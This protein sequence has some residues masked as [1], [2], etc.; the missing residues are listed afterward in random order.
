[1]Y[2]RCP[3]HVALPKAG[4]HLSH[5]S[6]SQYGA[7]KLLYWLPSYQPRQSG[8]VP[9]GPDPERASKQGLEVVFHAAFASPSYV[10]TAAPLPATAF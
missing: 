3:R 6:D 2:V 4:A 9:C 8:V 7:K 1:M 5:R 10:R